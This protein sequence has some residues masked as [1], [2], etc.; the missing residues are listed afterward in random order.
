MSKH[1]YFVKLLKKANSFTDSLL[2]KNLNKLNFLFQRDKILD[3]TRPKRVFIFIVVIFALV[4]SYLSIPFLYNKNIVITKLEN[5]LSNKFNTNFTFS[6]DINYSLYPWPNFTFKNVSI[7]EKNQNI[8]NIDE[9]K[10]V[11]SAKNFF[12]LNNF[13]VDTVLLDN[14]NFNLNNKNYNFFIKLL[15][16]DFLNSDFEISNSNIFYRNIY[17]E[18]LIIKKI[19]KMKYYYDHKLL[20][21][22]LDASNEIFNIPYSFTLQSDTI[23]DK[24]YSKINLNLLKLQLDNVYDYSGFKKN[25]LINLTHNKNNSEAKYTLNKNSFNFN[26][27]DKSINPKFNYKG[28]IN[29]TPFF[30]NLNGDT[31]N[32]DISKLFSSDSILTQFFKTEILNNKNLNIVSVINSNKIFPYD[33]MINLV[34]KIKVEEGLIDIDNTKFSWVDYVDF[35]ISDSLLYINDNNLILDGKFILNINN[36][37]EIYK[38]LQTPRNYRKQLKK[39]EFNF[40]YNFDQEI[41]NLKDIKI[42]DETNKK[43][44]KVLNQFISKKSKIENRVHFKKLM[45]EAIKSYA[46]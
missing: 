2:K 21:N 41:I 20:K 32:I 24:I 12:S 8:A 5:Q 38:F 33:N 35:E 30:L 28:N 40:N 14:V 45:N 27:F 9:L 23:N 19:H 10:I 3:F 39:I 44:N 42:N 43:V 34:A 15:D 18:V 46:G 22:T 13:K 29:F 37:N 6:K 25:G 31:E 7:L 1:N 4:I 17:E 11:L 36:F 26:F 16:N